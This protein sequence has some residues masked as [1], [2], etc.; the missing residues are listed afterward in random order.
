MNIKWK[1]SLATAFLFALGACSSSSSSAA[2]DDTEYSS[3][4]GGSKGGKSSSSTD[5]KACKALAEITL[6]A[7]SNL[8]VVKNGE[9]KWVLIWDYSANDD[10]PE[11]GFVVE[12]LDMSDSLPKWKSVGTTNTAVVMYNLEGESKSGKYYRVS[13]KDDCGVSKATD[14]VEIAATGAN[15]TTNADLATPSNL[16]LENLGDNMWQLSWSYTNNE[17][18]PEQGFKLQSLNLDDKSPKWSDDGTTNKGVHVVKID[19]NKKGGLLFHVAAKDDKG[20]SEYSEE[21]T[22]PRVTDSTSSSSSMD[23]AIPT[24]LKIDSI[25]VNKYQLSWSYADNTN[26]PENGF[27][28]QALNLTAAKPAWAVIDSTNKGV[29]F[30]IIDATKQGGRYIRVAA[31]DSKGTS[32]YSSE[33]QVPQADT[34]KVAGQEIDLAVPT[35]L[36]LTTLGDNQYLL[37]W[38]YTNN[39][40]RPENGFKLQSLNFNATNPQWADDGTTNKGVYVIKIDGNKKGGLLFRVAAKDSKGISEYSESIT[41]P[42]V[43]DGSG[44]SS[45]VDL[46][47]PTNLKADSIGVNKYQLSW[48]YTDNANRPE[49]GFRL[50]VLDLSVAKP[51]WANLDSTSKGVRLYNIDATKHGGKYIRVAAKDS[52]GVSTYSDEVMVPNADTTKVAGEELD[53]AVPKNLVLDPLG[54][55]EYLLSWSYTN[56]PKRPASGF[57]LQKLYIANGKNWEDIKASVGKDVLFYKLTA[58]S[59][60]YY[61]RIAAKD[62][63]GISEYSNVI[64]VPKKGEG[65][66]LTTPPSE[67]SISRIAPSVWELTWNYSVTVENPNRKFIIQSSKLKDFK[68]VDVGTEIKGNVRNYY[69]QG[70]DKIESYYRMAVVNDGDTSAFSDVIQLTPEIKYRD[71]MALEVPVPSEKFVLGYTTAY[72]ADKDTA[73]KND[74]TYISATATYTITENY[75]SKYIVESKYTDTVYYEARWFTSLE[76]YNYYKGSCEGKKKGDKCDSCY[77]VEPFPYEEPSITKRFNETDFVDKAKTTTIF[78]FCKDSSGYD[79]DEHSLLYSASTSADKWEEIMAH[80]TGMSMCIPGYVRGICG[81]YV[82]LRIVWKDVNGETDWSEWTQPFNVSD[83][84]GADDLCNPSK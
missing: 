53:L 5:S 55:N 78:E 84:S 22:I 26:R 67:L 35:K 36:T 81:Y 15:S 28:V 27:R 20:V 14:M 62:S 10:R 57:V 69:I 65:E 34:T 18:R 72:E 70:R 32:T 29:R 23:L 39:D 60:K 21:I 2:E 40:K 75:I 71:Y 42:S 79:A 43:S 8:Q 61:V 19:G 46:A 3:A 30:I 83:I 64:E 58:D 66:D 73:S 41:I 31:K 77:W 17:N 52:K 48:S 45:S 13:A 33:I 82:Q 9:N 76:Q 16:K 4:N 51:A 11:T 12:S 63:K 6:A 54:N 59:E 1:L 50:Q 68:W 7:P 74:I 44:T 80:E 25:G 24:S 47:V 56:T 38:S 37:S 49:N